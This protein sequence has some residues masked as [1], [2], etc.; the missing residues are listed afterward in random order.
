MENIFANAN[1]SVVPGYKAKTTARKID[2]MSDTVLAQQYIKNKE[3]TERAEADEIAMEAA[4][5]Y[6]DKQYMAS[7]VSGRLIKEAQL[8]STI[9]RFTKATKD[10]VFKAILYEIYSKSLVLD[11]DFV[12]EHSKDIGKLIS[13]YVDT[14]G[15]FS[16]LEEAAKKTKSKLLKKIKDVADSTANKVS[17]RKIKEANECNDPTCLNFDM[18]DEEKEEFEYN[19]NEIAPDEIAALVKKKVLTVV[20]DEKARQEKEDE[21]KKDI[22]EELMDSEDITDEESA[23]EAVDRILTNNNKVEKTTLFNALLRNCCG[24]MLIESTSVTYNSKYDVDTTEDDMLDSAP[25]DD[26]REQLHGELDMDRVLTEAL[27][28]Y[29]LMEM[30]YTLKLE[31]YSYNNIEKLTQKLIRPISKK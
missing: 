29:T 26:G 17:K 8:E 11:N 2:I 6:D 23:K 25:V 30:L 18:T 9:D 24:T 1:R 31:D 19:K 22:E 14:N 15:G 27:A 12:T 10:H 20:K 13:D 28:Q 3:A 5:A 4:Q 21:I 16:M 7:L